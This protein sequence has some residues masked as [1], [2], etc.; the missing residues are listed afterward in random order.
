MRILLWFTIG[1]GVACAFGCYIAPVGL[2]ALLI[3]CLL[4]SILA[5]VICWKFMKW[6]YGYPNR[7]AILLLG[8][9]I[10]LIWWMAF[11]AIR[12]QPVRK[13]DS[14]TVEAQV[15]ASD[16][17]YETNYRQAVDGK[18]DIDGKTFRVR[19]YFNG[20]E[21]Q[22]QPGDTVTGKF[23]I[24]MTVRGGERE[25]TY[26][27]GTG[28]YLLAYAGGNVT[29]SA[30]P[31]IRFRYFPAY[32]RHWI[33]GILEEIFPED[34]RA[35]AK[36]I[37]IGDTSD[38]D[39]ETD[40][41]LKVSGVRH[42][43]AVSGLHISILMGA[44]YLVGGRANPLVYIIGTAML[45]VYAAIV[46]FTPPITRALIMLCLLNLANPLNRE[47]DPPTALAFAGLVLMAV[48]PLAIRSAGFQLSFASLSGIFLFS[49]RIYDWLCDPKRFGKAK[50][51]SFGSKTKRFI[52]LSASVTLSASVFTVP[53]TAWYFG[54]VSLLG[55]LS[56]LLIIWI[57]SFVFCGVILSCIA[58]AISIPFGAGAAWLASVMIRYIVWT[59]KLLARFPLTA[60]YTASPYITVW[61]IACYLM[62]AIYLLFGKRLKLPYLEIG[63]LMLAAAVLLSF[64]PTLSR[65]TEVAVLD[66]GQGQSIVLQSEGKTF[67]VDCGGDTGQIAAD[68]AAEYLLSRGISR[69]DGVFLTHYDADHTAGM[70]FL[71]TRI[72]IDRVY[73]PLV[74]KLPQ[75]GNYEMIPVEQ[76]LTISYGKTDLHLFPGTDNGSSNDI[77]M[78]ILFQSKNCDILITGDR[79]GFGE[80]QLLQEMEPCKLEVLVV[81][82]HGSDGSTC[83]ALLQ[84]LRPE[85]AIISVGAG[86]PYGQ[87]GAE[88]LERLKLYGCTIHRTDL[89]GTI[90]YRG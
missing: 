9:S 14:Q 63:L 82:H 89:E 62:L 15:I 74:D 4:A 60:V 23:H 36:A 18:I 55:I 44:I 33:T 28:T 40:T 17:S 78:C 79:S 88:L 47:Y 24:Q 49:E 59:A 2:S 42:I 50:G 13:L 66:V 57:V 61:L 27:S 8:V 30:N 83:E 19:A 72:P 6:E 64:V 34:T 84:T 69:L 52:L 86:N 37:L 22:L 3:F 65:K 31:N 76:K 58:G 68:A 87:P 51:R 41:A 85:N 70:E 75:Y 45:F 20:Q 67:L 29:V 81:G 35:F 77:S 1:F 10:G 32:C 56:N 16:Y 46:G 80:L 71:S 90:I 5:A 48:N 73:G 12:I 53:L 43:V 11:D 38:L 25:P 21:V 26:H 54:T 7:A 39:Y